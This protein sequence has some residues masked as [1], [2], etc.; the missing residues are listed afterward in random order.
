MSAKIGI[1]SV[2]ERREAKQR[3]RER[4][5]SRLASGQISVRELSE[6]NGFFSKLG[7]AKAKLVV[8]RASVALK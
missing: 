2:K 3:S 6:E 5:L 8:R 4:D 7:N 1:Y